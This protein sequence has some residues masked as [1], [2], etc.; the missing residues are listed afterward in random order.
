[1]NADNSLTLKHLSDSD[2]LA[3]YRIFGDMGTY[4][5]PGVDVRQDNEGNGQI[6]KEITI[7]GEKFRF[8]I[9]RETAEYTITF[10][11]TK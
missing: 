5:N 3:A 11:D 4:S 8:S 7:D 2:R 10:Q 9:Y 6:S 1:M